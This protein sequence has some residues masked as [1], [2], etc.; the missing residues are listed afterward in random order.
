MPCNDHVYDHDDDNVNGNGS[1]LTIRNGTFVVSG[2]RSLKGRQFEFLDSVERYCIDKGVAKAL[3]RKGENLRG[4][5]KP[6]IGPSQT[7]Q[8]MAMITMIFGA[9][10]SGSIGCFAAYKGFKKYQRI[11]K[12]LD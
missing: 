4:Y 11:R 3:L 10:V 1:A 8:I 9:V 2:G 12:G 5:Q 7:L 6:Q